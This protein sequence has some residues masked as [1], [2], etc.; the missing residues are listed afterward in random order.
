L[1]FIDDRIYE[2]HDLER[3]NLT[4]QLIVVPRDKQVAFLKPGK[5]TKKRRQKKSSPA[6]ARIKGQPSARQQARSR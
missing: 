4:R 2:R 3:L 6:T 1:A 5:A